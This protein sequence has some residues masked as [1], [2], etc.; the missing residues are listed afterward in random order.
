LTHYFWWE[1]FRNREK[2]LENFHFFPEKSLRIF[3]FSEKIVIVGK[4]LKF[5]IFGRFE[6]SNYKKLS[7]G[8]NIFCEN[9]LKIG[10][11]FEKFNFFR[12]NFNRRNNF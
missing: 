1:H 5:T 10:K 9:I 2:V 4:N 6:F 11:N 7:F 12:Q 8:M 3:I